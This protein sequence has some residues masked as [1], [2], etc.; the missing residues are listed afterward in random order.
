MKTFSPRFRKALP[1]LLITAA[2]A[3]SL[4][5]WGLWKYRFSRL[6]APL[7]PLCINELSVSSLATQVGGSTI[8]EDYIELYNPNNNTISLD[9][10]YLSDT[11]DY[12]LAP[13]PDVTIGPG[14]HLCIYAAGQD[15][16]VPE[17]QLSVPFS[18]SENE[19]VSLTRLEENTAGTASSVLLDTVYI[20]DSMKIGAVYARTEDG[21]ETFAQMRPSPGTANQEAALVLEDPTFSQPS[22][23]YEDAVSLQISSSSG[24]TVHYTLDGSD[25]TTDSPLYSGSLT[26]MDPSSH[27]DRY[28]SRTDITEENSGYLPPDSPV[29]KAVVLRAVAFDAAGNSSNITTATYFIDFDQKDGYE[30]AAVLS[31]VTDPDNLFSSET[32][33]YVRGALYDD[34]M[35][36]G[37]IYNGL[38]W[39]YLTEYTN[40]YLEGAEAERPVYIQFFDASR[41]ETLAQDCGIRIRGNESRHFPQKSFSLY[42]RS[43]YGSSS[44]SPVF[45]DTGISYPNLILNSGRQLKK[46]FFFSLVEDRDTAIQQYT[47]C[48][49][50]LNGE[51]WGMYYL[52]EK[53]SSEYLAGHYD[54]APDNT[55]LVKDTR[56]VENGSPQD[57]A[58]YKELRTFLAEQNLADPDV[59]QE[60][61]TKMDMQ[62][63]IDWMC[64]N[65]YIANTDTKPLGGNV[66]TWQTLTPENDAED[67]RRQF[68]LTFLDMA[69]ES[70]RWEHVKALLENLEEQHAWADTGW[71]RWNTAPQTGTFEEQTA[72]LHTFFEHRAEYI[73]PMLAEHFGLQGPLVDI[74]LSSVPDKQGSIKLN[75]ISPDLSET[76]WNG[77]YYTDYPMTVRADSAKGY[78]FV[79]WEVDGGEIVSGDVNDPEIQVHLSGDVRITAHFKKEIKLLHAKE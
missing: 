71:M 45:F 46:I 7:K 75:T 44:F 79:R 6:E 76:D 4:S 65:I 58:R 35:E 66:L 47:P 31:L 55:L 70:F 17:G 30:N 19:T 50:F 63:F 54:V 29:D 28:A 14:A 57:I 68:V 39:T 78:R 67:F 18:L 53:Y 32:G 38:P 20:P 10:L 27:S 16:S 74:T 2:L 48:Q 49:V 52:M 73:I 34:A 43:L 62:S 24:T 11:S 37:L 1:V 72:E 5:A 36:A 41:E 12:T 13:L 69:N 77:Q 33:I 15:G 3:L 64:T 61:L 25:P 59:Y 56:Y 23:F 22:G 51:Y 60:L 26:L 40:Y 42:A 8:Y 9:G 21:G